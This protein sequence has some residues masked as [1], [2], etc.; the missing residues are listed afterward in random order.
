MSY[1][2]NSKAFFKKISP[3]E[4][5]VLLVEDDNYIYKIDKIAA[6]VFL[7]AIEEKMNEEKIKEE[8]IQITGKKETEVKLFLETFF[9]K[10]ME[11]NFFTKG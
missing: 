1:K 11:L 5:N 8:I 10:M 7:M 3:D 2:L 6:R 9:K 4:V